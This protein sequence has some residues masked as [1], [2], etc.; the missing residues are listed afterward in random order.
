[1]V[2]IFELT[3]EYKKQKLYLASLLPEYSNSPPTGGTCLEQ[4][5]EAM[6]LSGVS[7]GCERELHLCEYCKFPVVCAEGF[8]SFLSMEKRRQSQRIDECLS[9]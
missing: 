9:V 4:G 7:G 6:N 3:V 5:F 1:M 2:E 8:T